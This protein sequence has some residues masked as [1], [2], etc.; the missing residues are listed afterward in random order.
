MLDERIPECK[1]L[2]PE[3]EGFCT[4]SIAESICCWLYSR[5][6]T[7]KA[8]S[9]IIRALLFAVVLTPFAMRMSARQLGAPSCRVVKSRS[10]ASR[11]RVEGSSSLDQLVAFRPAHHAPAPRLHRIRGK[12][13]SIERGLA[14]TPRGYTPTHFLFSDAREGQQEVDG[15]NPSRGPPSQFSL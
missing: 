11:A 9:F 5:L 3:V 8:R 14:Q 1:N 2:Y 4:K 15:P 7:M 10:H 12:K 6:L 13:I